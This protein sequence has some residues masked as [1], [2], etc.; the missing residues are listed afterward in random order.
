MWLNKKKQYIIVV[1][2]IPNATHNLQLEQKLKKKNFVS[3]HS[4]LLV[5]NFI[6]VN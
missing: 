1:S 5:T 6:H 4:V 2:C 3:F